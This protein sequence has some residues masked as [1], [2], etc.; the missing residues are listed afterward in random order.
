MKT[1]SSILEPLF[2]ICLGGMLYYFMELTTRGHSHYSMMLCGGLSF[3][4]A[5]LINRY[6]EGKLSLLSRMILSAIVITLIELCFG[7][8]FN[9]YLHLHVWDYS[10]HLIQ[11][12]GQICLTFSI[13][14]FFLSLPIF[15]VEKGVRKGLFS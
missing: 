3:Y 6:F 1:L 5:S 13:L 4:A 12:K 11:Y 7:L 2:L 10:T 8:Y 14:W 9:L 15:W